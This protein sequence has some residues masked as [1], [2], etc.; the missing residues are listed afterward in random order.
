MC[1]TEH[2]HEP[3]LKG[4]KHTDSSPSGRLARRPVPSDGGL[5]RRRSAVARLRPAR[6]HSARPAVQAVRCGRCKLP[7]AVGRTRLERR[8]VYGER[9]RVGGDAPPPPPASAGDDGV[10]ERTSSKNTLLAPMRSA[11]GGVGWVQ[12]GVDARAASVAALD[13]QALHR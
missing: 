11:L 6:Q 1:L 12:P 5:G 13:R 9:L 7:D 8:Y 3:G 4:E 2:K 10:G